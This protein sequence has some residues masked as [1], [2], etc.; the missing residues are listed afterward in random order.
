MAS[1]AN[2]VIELYEGGQIGKD[3]AIRLVH[4]CRKGVHWCDGNE[5]EA[6]ETVVEAGYCGLCFEKKEGLSSVYDNGIAYP[7]K[8]DVLKAYD[9]T[10]AHDCLCPECKAKVIGEYRE[11]R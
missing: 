7:D 2:V 1:V 6:M 8:Y 9:K 11:K 4:A 3:A 5:D 10:A